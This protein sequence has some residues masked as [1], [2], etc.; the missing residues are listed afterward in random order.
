MTA[1]TKM[2]PKPWKASQRIGCIYAIGKNEGNCSLYKRKKLNFDAVD[3]DGDNDDSG[4]D[5]DVATDEE[6]DD[7]WWY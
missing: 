6:D 3:D 5:D 2:A 1:S 7:F 4:G